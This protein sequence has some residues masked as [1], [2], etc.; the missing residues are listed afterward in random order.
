MC[1]RVAVACLFRYRES[2]RAPMRSAKKAMNRPLLSDDEMARLSL[3]VTVLAGPRA[4]PLSSRSRA[5]QPRAVNARRVSR[6]FCT[7][8]AGTTIESQTDDIGTAGRA[9]TD[10]R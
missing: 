9:P 5:G 10:R 6:R 8:T 7:S 2:K 4:S 1:Q 3:S